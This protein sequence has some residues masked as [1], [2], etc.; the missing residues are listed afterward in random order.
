MSASSLSPLTDENPV[1]AHLTPEEKDRYWLEHVYQGDQMRQ[2]TVR[3]VLTGGLLGMLMSIANL[4]TT[5]KIGWAFGVAITACVLSYILWNCLRFVSG[6]RLTPMSV[7]ENNC[8]QS[9]ASA[10]GYSTGATIATAFGALLLLEGHHQPWLIVGSFTLCT[11]ALG[12]FLAVPMKRQMINH[13]QLPFPTGIA[14]AATLRSLYSEGKEALQK[15]QALIGG[16]VS[17]VVVGILNTGEG[18]LA[19]LDRAFHFLHLGWLRLPE[20]I[21]AQGFWQ[22]GQRQLI[23][24]G[25]EPSGL[26][27]GAGMITGIRV[28][29]SMLFGGSILYL[30]VGPALISLD[31]QCAGDPGYLISIPLVGSGTVYHLTRWSLWGGTALMVCAS[32]TSF[33]LQWPTLVRSFRFFQK[34]RTGQSDRQQTLDARLE[35]IEVPNAWLFFGIVPIFLVMLVIQYF[36]FHINFLLGSIAT[37]LAFALSLVACRATGET[38]TTPIGAMG[39]VVQLLFAV[40]SPPSASSVSISL[41]HNLMAASVA[42]NSAAS[43]A[44]LLTDLK[45]GYLLGANPRKQFL[46]QFV[47]IFFGTLAIVPAWYLMV[48]NKQVLESFNPPATNMWRAVA[49]LLAG[50]GF[51]ALP[52][53]AKWAIVGGALV[54]VLIP[55][56]EKLLPQ[57]RDWMPSAMGLGLSWVMTFNNCLSFAIGGVLISLWR[58]IHPDTGTTYGIPIASGLIAGESLIK[59]IIAMTATIL[60]LLT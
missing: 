35:A 11:A 58:K 29:L 2:L 24:F 38:D 4:Y 59:A 16:V 23:G 3:A 51:A 44:D 14:T 27:I 57:R 40:I 7:L 6:G 15:A 34:D 54:G 32:L 18:T 56:L 46:A 13:E 22:I 55:L 1:P 49:E 30:W 9:T 43:S 8:M 45:S 33:A 31:A 41:Q 53:S 25:F 37:I 50:S 36:A 48:P 21:P 5:L 42:A 47:G 20:L 60:G 10:A 28:G 12:V 39:K 26:L 17:G 19:F 52:V